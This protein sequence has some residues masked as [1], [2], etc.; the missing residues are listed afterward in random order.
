MVL[1]KPYL[2]YSQVDLW[3]KSPDRYRARYY[4]NEP[5]FENTE[6]AFGK[7][8]HEQ[9]ENKDGK[10]GEHPI[11]STVMRYPIAE[12]AIEVEIEGIPVFGKIDSYDPDLYAFIDFK[13]G[14]AKK[15]GEPPWD[16][17]AVRK[18]DQLPWYSMMIKAKEGKVN[19][20]CH[21]IWIE[22]VFKKKTM[23][24]DGEILEAD[25]R[26]LEL[27]GRVESFER[28]IE[29]WERKRMKDLLIKT[30]YEIEEDYKKFR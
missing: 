17:L 19:N 11:L 15:N 23:E 22:T 20:L 9:L 12:H 28:K 25:V 5:A 24:F 4:R 14:H 18:H 21:L 2:S 1:P 27:T 10:I 26:E 7:G 13:T 30:A 8:I 3:R 16:A 6:T 29:E